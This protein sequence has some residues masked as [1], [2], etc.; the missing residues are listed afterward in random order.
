MFNLTKRMSDFSTLPTMAEVIMRFLSEKL[1]DGGIETEWCCSRINEIYKLR[2][3][4]NGEYQVF[5]VSVAECPNPYAPVVPL[6]TELWVAVQIRFL[7]ETEDANVEHGAHFVYET[8]VAMS[9][10]VSSVVDNLVAP[11]LNY[12]WER[13]RNA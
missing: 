5:T 6:A 12:V 8:R 7:S 11:V 4:Y 3:K 10:Q 9:V 13:E 2:F 1:K